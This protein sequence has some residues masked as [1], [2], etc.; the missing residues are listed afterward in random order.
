M[1]SV[2]P[3]RRGTAFGVGGPSLARARERTRGLTASGVVTALLMLLLLY[4]AYDHGAAALSAGARVQTLAAALAAVAA[5]GVLWT[6]SLRLAAPRRAVLGIGMLGGFAL[7][8][9]VTLAWSIAPDATWTE[10]NRVLTYLLV[11]GVAVVIGASD[12]DAVELVARGFLLVAMAV[13]IYGL[14]QKLVPGLHLG[15]LVDL[16]RTGSFAR[17]PAPLGSWNALALLLA[18]GVPIA[19]AIVVDKS[20]GRG[21]R[22]TALSSIE[23]LLLTIV[24][25]YS[26]GG[27]LALVVGAGIGIAV[28]GARLR[29]LMW[30]GLALLATVPPLVIGLT[31]RSLTTSHIALG[32]R[33]RAGAELAAV[34]VV[35]LLALVL[36]ASRVFA[37]ERRAQLGPERAHRIGRLVALAAAV[38]L[39]IGVIAVA[40]SGRG[41]TGT[42]SHAWSS[43][44]ATK[45]ATLTGPN[46]LLSADSE[47][48]WV[49][50]KEAAGAFS[51]R[52]IGGWGAGSFA[53]I[54]LL[55]RH[56]NLSTTQAHSVPLQFLAET[57]IIGAALALGAFG[58][59]LAV[60]VRAVRRLPA[61]RER[62]LAAA[63]LA[64]AATYAV[65]ATYD[66]DWA[67]PGVTLPALTFLGVLAGAAGAGR[68]GAPRSPGFGRALGLGA[69]TLA[70]CVVAF[71]GVLPSLAAS[72]A[73][74][75]LLAAAQG[76]PA[77]LASAESDA[78]DA[79]SFDPLSDQ[80]LLVQATIDTRRGLL[81][82]AR[83]D[84]VRAI[85]R[86][87]SDVN[88][89][90]QLS[91][92]EQLLGNGSA[93]VAAAQRMLALDPFDSAAREIADLAQLPLTP[94]VDS[95]TSVST[96]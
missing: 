61:G 26:R 57:G 72:R 3:A 45:G 96:P 5:A 8:C 58:L 2:Q 17:L 92:V 47:N 15:S 42:V 94:A 33:E 30:A 24:L 31:N 52:P 39:A 32:P 87:P 11:L 56:D 43:F 19:L 1:S 62:L 93:D 68:G 22:L 84:L 95:A 18:M 51:D 59:L 83:G 7:W 70:L 25:T 13:A 28:S 69:V 36:V 48:R 20:A 54:H 71:S 35:S 74:A 89:W 63:L 66:W 4:A 53:T 23:L 76:T 90:E 29:S 64:G 27:L 78:R 50:W 21:A 49:W 88:A 79:T 12:R 40:L 91:T 67:I 55:Y 65:H 80:G 85:D 77:A 38:A 6:G 73:G 82:A 81:S 46:R 9:A 10:F 34:L 44:T 37:A 16:N 86:E 41:L 14:G 60:A 75:A